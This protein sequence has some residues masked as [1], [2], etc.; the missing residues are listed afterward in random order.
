M[1]EKAKETD[2]LLKRKKG[3]QRVRKDKPYGISSIFFVVLISLIT[4]VGTIT[5][6]LLR[7]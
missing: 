7:S 3:I 5:F 4:I 2:E 6:I 1:N